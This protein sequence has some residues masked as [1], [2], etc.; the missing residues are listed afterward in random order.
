[1]FLTMVSQICGENGPH[2]NVIKI[3]RSNRSEVQMF[4]VPF[5]NLNFLGN[6][7]RVGG[8]QIFFGGE[9][10]LGHLSGRVNGKRP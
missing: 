1:M 2:S 4:C 3:F 8:G 7:A 10:F 6:L 9:N 5:N